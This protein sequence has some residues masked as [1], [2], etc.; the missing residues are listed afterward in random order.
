LSIALG[1]A[2]SAQDIKLPGAT[3]ETKPGTE[4]TLVA[5]PPNPPSDA[6][7]TEL[8]GWILAKEQGLPDFDLTPA[9]ID[10]LIKGFSDALHHKEAPV[11]LQKGYPLQEALLRGIEEKYLAGLK[12]KNVQANLDFFA[13]LKDSRPNLQTT[14]SGLRYEIIAAGTG[15]YPKAT[16]TVRV[17]Y[18]G[19]LLDGTVFDSSI[20]RGQPAEF[21]LNGVIPG[22]T[23]GI[24]K[25]NKGGSI[26]LY[27]PPEL[28]YGESGRP[29]IPPNAALIFDV[30]LLDIKSA[31][32]E[33]H[34]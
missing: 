12:T 24:Q 31:P 21:P 26:R 10:G 34:P 23:E 27:I 30:K 29:G 19:R 25:I 3:P 16:D 17:D 28:G 8:H 18:E 15:D 7:L 33:A 4:Q 13:R 2:A 5:P 22:W 11:D 6:Q 9:E 32:A 20:Q 14:P 1:A